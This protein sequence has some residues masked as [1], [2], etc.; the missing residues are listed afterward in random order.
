M[1]GCR[2]ILEKRTQKATPASVVLV[3]PVSL[4]MVK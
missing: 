3:R 4:I 1:T 2:C